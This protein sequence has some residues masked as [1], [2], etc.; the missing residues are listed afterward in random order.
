MLV[1]G[2]EY[3]ITTVSL[4]GPSGAK[5]KLLTE[6]IACSRFAHSAGAMDNIQESLNHIVAADGIK[7]S[8]E[9]LSYL[10]CCLLRRA[11]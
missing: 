11:A 2:E 4:P 1:L 10:D 8:G 7:M 3:S 9:V 6:A 5:P